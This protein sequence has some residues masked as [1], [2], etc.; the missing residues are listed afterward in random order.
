MIRDKPQRMAAGKALALASIWLPVGWSALFVL[1][2]PTTDF[3]WHGP[4]PDNDL[5]FVVPA[6]LVLGTLFA[7]PLAVATYVLLRILSVRKTSELFSAS[8]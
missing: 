4:E 5:S 2:I 1:C 8:D 6:C 3:V 7:V